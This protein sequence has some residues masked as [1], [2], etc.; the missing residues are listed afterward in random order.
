MAD[1]LVDMAIFPAG[2]AEVIAN[3]F[4]LFVRA[5][6]SDSGVLTFGALE[7]VGKDF[8]PF[9]E[10]LLRRKPAIC[11]HVEC[12]AEFYDP[13]RL[14]D[15]LAL[16]YHHSRNYLEGFWTAL[17]ELEEKGMLEILAAHHQRFGNIYDDSH[18]YV[19]WRPL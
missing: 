10:F 19:V 4:V 1:F 16:A 14:L 9:L 18:S 6:G 13:A 2:L 7:Q 12:I 11:V 3:I 15:Y 5:L 17:K 8:R